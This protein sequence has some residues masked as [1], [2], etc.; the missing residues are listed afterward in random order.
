M[1]EIA[2]R[3]G[4]R[5]PVLGLGTWGMGRR[6]RARA[7]EVAAL[8]LGY[9][10]GA[11]LVDTAE[12]YA[13]GGAEEVVGESLRGRRERIF[14]VTKVLPQNAS[15][16][17]TVRAAEASLRRLGIDCIDLYLLHWPGSHPLQETLEAFARLHADGKLRHWGLSNVDTDDLR[18]AEG[19]PGGDG[20]AADQVYYNL[21]H[22]GIER[23]LVLWCQQR[24]I[25]VMAYSPL[26]QGRLLHRKALL[27]V[28][29][30]HG[31]EPAQA[32]LAW[33]LR[34]PGVVAIP[35]AAGSQHVRENAAA[36]ALVLEP[37]DLTRLE[38]AFPP[39]QRDGPL[40][41]S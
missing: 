8:Q 21:S 41:M 19:L 27:E 9:D 31:V 14:V 39:P 2:T 38:D 18:S 11:T 25:A 37:E 26:D 36:A 12:M 32:A 17:G 24:E 3:T 20:I 34:V 15:R 5:M 16:A 10:L 1:R 7:S 29:R 22:R 23:R 35:K 33:T 28:A 6:R 13:D 30:R 40:E 4:A